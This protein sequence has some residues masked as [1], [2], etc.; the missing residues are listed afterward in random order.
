MDTEIKSVIVL[1]ERFVVIVMMNYQLSPQ[2]KANYQVDPSCLRLVLINPVKYKQHINC[3][4]HAFRT[5][6]SVMGLFYWP[7]LMIGYSRVRLIQ[8]TMVCMVLSSIER[9]FID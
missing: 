6:I 3:F 2:K 4:A 7:N 8:G 9:Q 1:L 5:P